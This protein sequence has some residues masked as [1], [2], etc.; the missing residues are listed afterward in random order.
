MACA[1][2]YS[3]SYTKE[4]VAVAQENE[5]NTREMS[6][7]KWLPGQAFNLALISDLFPS[8]AMITL[9]HH[10]TWRLSRDRCQLLS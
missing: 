4:K 10:S 1:P 7:G 9:R 3:R 6:Q 5:E 8:S 2:L